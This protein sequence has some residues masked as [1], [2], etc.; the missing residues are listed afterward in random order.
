MFKVNELVFWVSAVKSKGTDVKRFSGD[1]PFH[2]TFWWV[3]N[4]CKSVLRNDKWDNLQE[5][6]ISK[7]AMKANCCPREFPSRIN[8]LRLSELHA[9]HSMTRE[10]LLSE[11]TQQNSWIANTTLHGKGIITQIAHTE[12]IH[13]SVALATFST[14]PVH[15]QHNYGWRLRCY[16]CKPH[17]SNFPETNKKKET[18]VNET[19]ISSFYLWHE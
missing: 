17:K 9:T 11:Q 6:V 16:E 3:W 12:Q 5:S 2:S 4:H 15:K 18:R 19:N 7:Y 10:S 14:A 8:T 1:M 13:L